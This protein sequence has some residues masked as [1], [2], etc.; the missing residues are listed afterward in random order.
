MQC[1]VRQRDGIN[2]SITA[3]AGRKSGFCRT[4]EP[5]IAFCSLGAIDSFCP[6]AVY[7]GIAC[8]TVLRLLQS[9][10]PKSSVQKIVCARQKIVV[11]ERIRKS[12][13]R[14]IVFIQGCFR[15]YGAA[16]YK[17]SGN[18]GVG[19]ENFLGAGR[20]PAG[21]RQLG[22][23]AYNYRLFALIPRTRQ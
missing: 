9:C 1:F 19:R 20:Q 6:C 8:D 15:I 23:L 4:Y 3:S 18:R 7:A 22:V 11:I 16:R 14:I 21:D 10:V 17:K 5:F 12:E 2:A 13:Y